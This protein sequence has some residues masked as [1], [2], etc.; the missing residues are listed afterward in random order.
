[1]LAG[2]YILVVDGVALFVLC[3]LFLGVCIGEAR[4]ES[5]VPSR[6]CADFSSSNAIVVEIGIWQIRQL[7]GRRLEIWC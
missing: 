7:V 3:Q 2:W 1:M 6:L 5:V 4:T